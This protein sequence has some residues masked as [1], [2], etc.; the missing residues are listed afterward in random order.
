MYDSTNLP[1][2]LDFISYE[3]TEAYITA[4]Y[5]MKESAA[6]SEKNKREAQKAKAELETERAEKRSVIMENR[7]LKRE[8]KNQ[9][10]E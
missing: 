10:T 1:D 6:Q 7:L 8:K 3:D 4:Q 9:S 5:K 2:I